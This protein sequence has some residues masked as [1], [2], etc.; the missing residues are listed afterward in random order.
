M[1]ECLYSTQAPFVLFQTAQTA[2]ASEDYSVM[3]ENTSV[4]RIG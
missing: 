3:C 4:D 2:V 1:L